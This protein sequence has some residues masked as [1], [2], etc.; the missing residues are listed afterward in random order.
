VGRSACEDKA[1]V[2]G[3]LGGDGDREVDAVATE[4]ICPRC[5][6]ERVWMHTY[7]KYFKCENCG[8]CWDKSGKEPT[9]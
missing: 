2:V 1:S 3:L 6:T 8:K 4:M 7:W 9:W 5:K